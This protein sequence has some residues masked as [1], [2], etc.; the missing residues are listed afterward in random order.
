MQNLSRDI[1]IT[2]KIYINREQPAA[3]LLFIMHLVISH[4]VQVLVI[5]IIEVAI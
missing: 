1:L 3:L 4:A 5:E 2:S